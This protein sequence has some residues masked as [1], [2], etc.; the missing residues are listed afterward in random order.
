V[1]ET[2]G[3]VLKWI[4]IGVLALVALYFVLRG[5]A[6]ITAWA[7]GLLQALQNLWASI[8][9]KPKRKRPAAGA[10]AEPPAPAWL[11]RPFAAYPDPFASGAAGRY[12]PEHLVKYSYEALEA[13]ACEQ[14]LARRPDETALEF[15][16]RLGEQ[17]PTLDESARQLAELYARVLYARPP[18]PP[19][20]LDVLRRFWQQLAAAA[21]TAAS[22][23]P[24]VT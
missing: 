2:I 17:V 9:G 24:S 18:L 11:P 14:G 8:F 15:A 6:N 23:A 12:P 3:K 5:L 19:A 10:P 13:W 22:S 20:C 21:P 1:L 16:E 4:A 7:K